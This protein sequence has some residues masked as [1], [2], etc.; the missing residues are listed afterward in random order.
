MK[1]LICLALTAALLL[2]GLSTAFAEDALVTVS[3]PEAGFSTRIP[4]GLEAVYDEEN[5]LQIFTEHPGYIP[6]V[7]VYRRPPE[8]K[9]KDPVNFLNNVYR[10][11]MENTYGDSMIGTNPCKEYEVGGKKLYGARYLYQVKGTTLCLLRL[12][13]VRDDGDVEYS[14]KYIDGSGEATLAVLESAVQ[15]YRTD[16][17]VYDNLLSITVNGRE[18]RLGNSTVDDFIADGWA[19]QRENDG[20]YGFFSPENESWFYAKTVNGA[21]DAPIIYLD[22]WWADGVSVEYQGYGG[23]GEALTGRQEDLWTWLK[24][25]FDAKQNEDGALAAAAPLSSGNSLQIETNGERVRLAI[26]P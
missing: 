25:A 22:M 1:R 20:M 18:Y 26:V 24:T 2:A 3:C 10:E 13:E 19:F 23:E 17:A 12:I 11:Y 6:Y 15:Y 21:S 16:G 8:G 14:A 9:F 7:L 5:G 4:A